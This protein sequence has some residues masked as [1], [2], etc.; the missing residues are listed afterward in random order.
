MNAKW[1]KQNLTVV[2]AVALYVAVMGLII[3]QQQRA[4]GRTQEI[5]AQLEEQ[6]MQLRSI[7]NSKPFPS[8]E[9]VRVLRTDREQIDQQYDALHQA[10]CVSSLQIPQAD[11]AIDFFGVLA[12]RVGL[13]RQHARAGNVRIPDNFSFGF[14]HYASVPPATEDKAVLALLSK[15]LAAVQ[16]LTDTLIASR[17]DEI[18]AIRRAD[19]EGGGSGGDVLNEPVAHDP[20]ALY[21]V[22]PF[23]FQFVGRQAALQQFLNALLQLDCFFTIHTLKITTEGVETASATT[24]GARPAPRVDQGPDKSRLVVTC[25][26]DLVEFPTGQK[27][28]A[29]ESPTDQKSEATR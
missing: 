9:N 4:S 10:V 17:V 22:L 23:E 1:F 11:R 2:I 24:G 6:Q 14:G 15:Q 5:A 16:K 25:H 19:V 20:N 7:L 3:W 12:Q 13:L 28:E 26:I 8:Q 29:T 21:Q 27:A 18:L